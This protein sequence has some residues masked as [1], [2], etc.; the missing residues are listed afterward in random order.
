[1]PD[2]PPYRVRAWR[3]HRGLSQQQLADRAGLSRRTVTG[4]ETG[5]RHWPNVATVNALAAALG[6]H[7]R[8]LKA[9]PPGPSALSGA[10]NPRRPHP[11]MV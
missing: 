9:D 3:E 5:A 4:L 1:M 10:D 8:D 2:L 6:V 7:W 11:R